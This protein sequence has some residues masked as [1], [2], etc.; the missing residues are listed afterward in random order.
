MTYR[1]WFF[2]THAFI[3]NKYYWAPT[4]AR[5]SSMECRYFGDQNRISLSFHDRYLG[6]VRKERER[7]KMSTTKP[8]ASNLQ[9]KWHDLGTD[10]RRKRGKYGK[11]E[12]RKARGRERSQKDMGVVGDAS[13]SHCPSHGRHSSRAPTQALRPEGAFLLRREESCRRKR[14]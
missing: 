4:C 7:T 8:L 3:F 1:K 14:H 13:H 6:W 5:C 9:S 10:M 11:V 2:F 12:E